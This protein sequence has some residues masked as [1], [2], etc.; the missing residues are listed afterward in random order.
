M[1]KSSG[2]LSFTSSKSLKTPS[3]FLFILNL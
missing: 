3:N 2:I 1:G